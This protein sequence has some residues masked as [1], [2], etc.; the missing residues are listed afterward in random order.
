MSEYKVVYR[1]RQQEVIEKKSRFIASVIPI[2]SEE[3]ALRHIESIRKEYWNATHNCYA[4][5]VGRN[6]E[7]QRFSDDGEPSG[8]AGKPILDVLLGE[9][10]HNALIVVTRY[11]GGTLLGTGGLVRAYSKSAKAALEESV[12][13]NKVLGKK[14]LLN[15]D[16]NTVGKIQ[17]IMA[18][19]NVSVV[20][21][22]YKEDVDMYII[23]PLEDILRISKL[24]MEATSAK[25]QCQELDTL[26]F[27]TLNSELLTF[28]HTDS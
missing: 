9:D 1:G 3:D 5:V 20:D 26:Y 10:I 14:I 17:Y 25:V 21:T 4:Y 28:E 15:M 19:N 7:L 11:F 2:E 8:T 13:I 12:I 6:Q 23:L 27:A 22:V 16:Y 24:I 18:Q